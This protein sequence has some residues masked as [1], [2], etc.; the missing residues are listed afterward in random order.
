MW[1]HLRLPPC[2]CHCLFIFVFSEVWPGSSSLSFFPRLLLIFLVIPVLCRGLVH[3]G[4][5]MFYAV[6]YLYWHMFSVHTYSHLA[7]LSHLNHSVGRLGFSTSN[8]HKCFHSC[9][10]RA[11]QLRA[12]QCWTHH[13]VGQWAIRSQ[14]K[15][16]V[17]WK[18]AN[19]AG[20]VGFEM[21][22]LWSVN[23]PHVWKC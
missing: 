16:A 6:F 7:L 19:L 1:A 20:P 8:N 2:I 18:M 11:Q 4:S 15:G 10:D 13:L 14:F 12:H 3:I 22:L 9:Y 17:W 5:H 23:L 21:S